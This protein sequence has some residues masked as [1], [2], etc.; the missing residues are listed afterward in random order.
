MA[1]RLS[2]V[3]GVATLL[4]AVAVLLLLLLLLDLLMLDLAWVLLV[5][6][7]KGG[8]RRESGGG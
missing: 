6:A 7:G 8:R 4:V 1:L 5:P 2:L 3:P